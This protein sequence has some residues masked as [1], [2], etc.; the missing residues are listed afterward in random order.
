M[1]QKGGAVAEK[2]LT[3]EG[4]GQDIG[5]VTGGGNGAEKDRQTEDP[6][7]IMA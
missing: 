1:A 6:H 2:G 3:D 4:F 7:T 5:G